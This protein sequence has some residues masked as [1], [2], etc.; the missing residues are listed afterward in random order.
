M[1][2]TFP[3]IFSLFL[4]PIFAQIKLPAQIAN[5]AFVPEKIK[6]FMRF[7]P[8]VEYSALFDVEQNDWKIDMTAELYF[9]RTAK[10]KSKKTATF[11]WAD[12]RLLPKEE[13][14]NKE[15]YWI[16]QY[17]Y[18]NTL[19]DP[20][21]YS[22]EEIGRLK[23]F[24][25]SE[26]RKN[27]GGTPMFFFDFLYS[28]QS[29]LV[30]EDHIIKTTFLGKSTRIHER[31]YDPIK[32]VEKKICDLAEISLETLSTNA[33]IAKIGL[34][35]GANGAPLSAEAKEAREFLISLKSADAY[36]WR[37]IAGTS[38]KSFHSYG[39]A[40]DVLPKRLNG[41]AIYWGW[42]KDRLGDKWMLVPLEKRWTPPASVR[43]IFESEGFIWGGYWIIFD[44]MHFE[45]HPEL[46]RN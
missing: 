19:R 46:V 2:R 43:K 9:E 3:L 21:T 27:E 17:K 30:I 44:N 26:N 38:R 12:G 31:I 5:K 15:N 25:S 11:Y 20:K 41:K 22:E 34:E 18:E 39:T 13:L 10:P 1:K 14:S 35:R 28:A 8:D 37:E 29:K 40:I 36:Y 7:Y 24:G 23:D 32:N 42:E 45:Y 33:Q 4:F 6:N 16:L